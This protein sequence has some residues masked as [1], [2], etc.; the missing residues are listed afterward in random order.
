MERL[1][2]A[3]S[4]FGQNDPV[5]AISTSNEIREIEFLRLFRTAIDAISAAR[6]RSSAPTEKLEAIVASRPEALLVVTDDGQVS[7]VN[8]A[9]K[10]FPGA[11]NVR[12]GTSVFAG[13]ERKS[14]LGAME[15]AVVFKRTVECE[16]LRIDGLRFRATVNP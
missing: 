1:R 11:E 14:L 10:Q 12:V 8:F 15:Q 16:L 2:G 6:D 7:V 13:I 4:Q 3:I 5:S 9:A